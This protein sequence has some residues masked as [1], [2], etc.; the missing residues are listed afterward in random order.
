MTETIL[1]IEN[2]NIEFY[3]RFVFCH[4]YYFIKIFKFI[5]KL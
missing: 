2:L 3:L 5:D 4:L 1:N